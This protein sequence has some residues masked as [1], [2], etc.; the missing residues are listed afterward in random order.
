MNRK[1][2]EAAKR[3]AEY[4]KAQRAQNKIA[5]IKHIEEK[6]INV[7]KSIAKNNQKQKGNYESWF[8]REVAKKAPKLLQDSAYVP[9]IK[10]LE[11]QPQRRDITE[12]KP[13]GKGRESLFVSLAE[14]MLAL[15][16]TPKF[17]WSAFWEEDV[18]K[19]RDIITRITAGESFFKMCQS[20][21]SHQKNNATPF[22]IAR[23]NILSCLRFAR[24]KFKPI[25]EAPVYTTHG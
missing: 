7:L 15:Y 1:K 5:N 6:E 9:S 24:F 20:A 3:S 23:R 2:R 18:D 11:K 12:W 14:H 4:I 25:A 13:K 21:G 10:M 17:L 16:P 22:S 8:L 19:L